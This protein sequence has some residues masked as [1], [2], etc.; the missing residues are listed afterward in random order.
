MTSCCSASS[1][2]A[3]DEH[4]AGAEAFGFGLDDDGADFGEVRAVEME[5][6]AAEEL[7][8]VVANGTFGDGEVADVFAEL[9]VGAAEERAVAGERVDEVEDV[10]CVLHAGFADDDGL[11][12]GEATGRFLRA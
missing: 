1:A 12:R 11:G 6:A 2:R 4:A 3:V 7:G 5:R 8:G 10:A 9:G